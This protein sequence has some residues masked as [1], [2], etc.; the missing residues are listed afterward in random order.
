MSAVGTYEVL[1]HEM[2]AHEVLAHDILA[3]KVLAH[4]MPAHKSVGSL[5]ASTW[6]VGGAQKCW[7]VKCV[8]CGDME[9]RLMKCW[10]VKYRHI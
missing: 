8:K 4:E 3:H 7:H 10:H 1:A 5:N 9:C 6:S 2:P